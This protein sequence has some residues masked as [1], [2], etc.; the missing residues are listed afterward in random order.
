MKLRTVATILAHIPSSD[1]ESMQPVY[2]IASCVIRVTEALK[3]APV[4][5]E[6]AHPPLFGNI[7]MAEWGGRG[8]F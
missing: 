4:P 3:A 6:Y 7:T 2:F 8:I 1:A 5:G